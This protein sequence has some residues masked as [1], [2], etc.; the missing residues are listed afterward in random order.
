M[1]V[2]D[3]TNGT[4]LCAG[5]TK[6]HASSI[7]YEFSFWS[8]I[9]IFYSVVNICG[10]ESDDIFQHFRKGLIYFV[11][12]KLVVAHNKYKWSFG[13]KLASKFF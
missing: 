7:H 5:L 4:V 1:S 12:P 9:F 11:N 6:S 3:I 8:Q 10:D 13:G 2:F